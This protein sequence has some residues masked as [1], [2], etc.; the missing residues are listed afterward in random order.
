MS[1][2]FMRI[3]LFFDL[4]NITLE[5]KKEYRNFRKFLIKEGFFMMQ[6]SV[7]CKLLL[8][9]TTLRTIKDRIY[10]N[11]PKEGL[12]QFIAITEK[13]YQSM[14]YVIGVKR[15]DIIDSDKGVI[16]L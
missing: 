6:E 14:E 5:D 12:I 7:Y 15:S 10:K 16:L 9:Q 4:P 8:N 1:Y 2:R 13:Q 3:L 11:K